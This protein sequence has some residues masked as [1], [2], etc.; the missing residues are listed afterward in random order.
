MDPGRRQLREAIQNVGAD[1]R[2]LPAGGPVEADVGK[3]M[4]K[5]TRVSFT[6]RRTGQLGGQDQP[7]VRPD[8]SR[9][10][11]SSLSPSTLVSNTGQSASTANITQ[12]YALGFRL[13]DHGQ[14]YEIS[15]VSIDL[16]AAPSS[17]TVSLWSGGVEGAFQAN[18]ATSYSTLPTRPPSPSA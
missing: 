1:S 8:Q 18:T 17:L 7:A 15:S 6:G 10:P 13:G 14:G 4:I 11:A 5:V 16:A 3:N 12:Q 2:H 9:T